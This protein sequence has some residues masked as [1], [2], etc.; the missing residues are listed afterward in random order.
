MA[1]LAQFLEDYIF[2][3]EY[4][5]EDDD[6]LRYLLRASKNPLIKQGLRSMLLLTSDEDDWKRTIIK[7]RISNALDELHELV[8]TLLPQD[9]STVLRNNLELELETVA[10][11]WERAQHSQSHFEVNTNPGAS[12]WTWKSI[13]SIAQGLVLTDVDSS[14]FVAS[15][16]VMVVFPRVFALDRS[17]NPSF[18]PVF[19]GIILQE[20]RVENLQAELPAEPPESVNLA[21]VPTE[22][23]PLE[24]QEPKLE[25]KG[26]VVGES[27]ESSSPDAGENDPAQS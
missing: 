23:A 8:K 1:I 2:T 22:A 24:D 3:P 16:R 6:D 13:S 12:R 10:S 4:L 15:E 26:E 9:M 5:L 21:V 18:T 7:K 17:Q 20:S 11:I 25:A 14:E 27:A 19:T